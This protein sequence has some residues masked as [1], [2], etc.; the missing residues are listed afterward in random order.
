MEALHKD[1][2]EIKGMLSDLSELM[3]RVLDM[4]IE[5]VYEEELTEEEKKEI[6]DILSGKA[7]L[8]TKEEFE[9]F[10]EDQ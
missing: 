10:L 6:E 8:L 3:L 1:I 9:K 5:P 7:E 2:L 4:E